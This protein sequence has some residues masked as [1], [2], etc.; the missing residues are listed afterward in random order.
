MEQ[1]ASRQLPTE[2]TFCDPLLGIGIEA[3]EANAACIGIPSFSNSVWY[4]SIPVPVW[5]FLFQYQAGSGIDIFFRSG[6]GMT[7]CRTV[8]RSGIKKLYEGG[9]RNTLHVYTAG[10]VEKYTLQAILLV[11][12]CRTLNA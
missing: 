1:A 4:R 5:V 8:R 9:K 10:N 3:V 11:P 2:N 6:T 12:E 7:K